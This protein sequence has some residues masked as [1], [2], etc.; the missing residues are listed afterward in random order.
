MIL[1]AVEVFKTLLILCNYEDVK[2]VPALHESDHQIIK[3]EQV[4]H[5]LDHS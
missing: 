1:V 4:Q 2:V 5:H 3:V